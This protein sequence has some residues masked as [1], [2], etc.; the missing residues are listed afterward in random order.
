MAPKSFRFLNNRKGSSLLELMLAVS[1][2]V[3]LL[4]SFSMALYGTQQEM[5]AETNYFSASRAV[6]IGFEKVEKDI[7]E[8]IGITASY[9]GAT[10]GDTTLILKLPSIDA[11]GQPI[12]IATTFDYVTYELSGTSLLRSTVRGSGS[13]RDGGVNITDQVIAGNL[14]TVYFSY[15]GTGLSSISAA[16]LPTL[17]YVNVSLASQLTSTSSAVQT[18]QTSADVSL[19]NNIT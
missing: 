9:N 4:A 10:T 13:V 2:S 18:A 14:N 5:T 19:V 11:T 7:R 15:N 3:V 1:I 17:K 8:A 12:N 6:R 16:T